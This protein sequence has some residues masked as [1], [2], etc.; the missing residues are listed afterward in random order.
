MLHEHGH[1]NKNR[2]CKHVSDMSPTREGS[3]IRVV[4]LRGKKD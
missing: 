1:T 2:A 4:V 3:L